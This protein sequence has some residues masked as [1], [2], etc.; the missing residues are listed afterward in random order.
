[1]KIKTHFPEHLGH[2]KGSSKKEVYSY[3]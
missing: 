2:R 3:D 1:V